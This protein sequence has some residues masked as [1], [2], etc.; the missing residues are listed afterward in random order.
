[1]LVDNYLKKQ[2]SPQ[3]EILQRLRKLILKTIPAITEE[4]KMGVPWYEG[5]FYLV[6]LK[7]HVNLGFSLKGL[8]KQEMDFFEGSGKTMRHL[9][10]FSVKEI[11][12]KKVVKLLK[13]LK[14]KQ[15]VVFQTG[16]KFGPA[17]AAA[18]L[19][20]L[21]FPEWYLLFLV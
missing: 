13:K 16:P 21:L 15:V 19:I 10:F 14:V 8:S 17:I 3:K 5:K 20:S 12:Q 6:S 2:P 1:M 7:D 18:V 11:D 4:M 9:K